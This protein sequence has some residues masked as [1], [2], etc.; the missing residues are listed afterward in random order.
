MFK[1]FFYLWFWV[2][3]EGSTKS[4]MNYKKAK[5]YY[6]GLGDVNKSYYGC[7]II[8]GGECFHTT[9]INPP[10]TFTPKYVLDELITLSIQFDVDSEL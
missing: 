9:I 4:F 6:H 5:E 1:D 2:K 10:V 8:R 7:H 3:S